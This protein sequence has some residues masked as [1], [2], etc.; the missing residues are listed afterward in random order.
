MPAVT[1]MEVVFVAAVYINLMKGII[2]QGEKSIANSICD[3]SN[4]A[5]KIGVV[6]S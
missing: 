6:V 5:S 3:S 1:T 4:G 2:W